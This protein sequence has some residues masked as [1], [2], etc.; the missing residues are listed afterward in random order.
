MHAQ[1]DYTAH[2]RNILET[3]CNLNPVQL[4]HRDIPDHDIWLV[5]CCHSHGFP[6]IP[7]LADDFDIPFPPQN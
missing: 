4:G 1:Y 3:Q 5:L 7:S 6:T 2:R